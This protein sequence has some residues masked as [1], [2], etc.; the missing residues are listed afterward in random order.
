MRL[1][2]TL[3]A[4]TM[5][6]ASEYFY[7]KFMDSSSSDEDEYEDETAMMYAVLEDAQRAEEHVVN[8]K[9]SIKGHRVLNWKRARGH[10]MLMDDYCV[11]N[12][13][14]ESFTAVDSG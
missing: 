3:E 11:P 6:S 7:A 4:N 13:L 12:V 2:F 1:L 10:M 9:E 8:F 5:N 14:F